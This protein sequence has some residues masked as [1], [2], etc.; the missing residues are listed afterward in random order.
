MAMT[1]E[2]FIE[3]K[4]AEGARDE[5]EDAAWLEKTPEAYAALFDANEKLEKLCKDFG[6]DSEG[7][8]VPPTVA[9]WQRANQLS[10]HLS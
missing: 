5:A 8:T 10:D 7:K 3:F 9:E 4:L 2:Q 6:V 1:K